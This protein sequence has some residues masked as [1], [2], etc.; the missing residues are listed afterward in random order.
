MA[1]RID[2]SLILTQEFSDKPLPRVLR[3]TAMADIFGY[4]LLNSPQS[5]SLLN[6]WTC[7]SLPAEPHRQIRVDRKM[8]RKEPLNFFLAAL[9]QQK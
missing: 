3:Q 7:A 8:A 6:L 9:P 5:R 1:E 4:D 2:F